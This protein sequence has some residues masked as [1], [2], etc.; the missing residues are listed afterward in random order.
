MTDTQA[1]PRFQSDSPRFLDALNYAATLHA[2][3]VR[4]ATSIPYVAHVLSVAGIAIEHGADE[5]EAI[6]ALLH[7]APEDCGGLHVL[8]E[9]RARFG[10][11]VT[12]IVAACSDTFET[13]KPPWVERKVR[14]IAHV[15]TASPSAR[16]VSMSDKLHNARAI[17]ADYRQL[18][19]AVFSR[20]KRGE[21]HSVLW[22][23]RRL[24]DE[25]NAANASSPL[26]QELA[27]VVAELETLTLAD[28]ASR[29]E[30]RRVYDEL[31]EALAAAAHV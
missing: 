1:S 16:L 8:E 24:A 17:L 29:A 9:I 7:D 27:R 25:F 28:D 2:G 18:G 15:R 22:Y 3:Q 26:A 14:Y 11:R 6:A 12:G 5:D 20:F 19:E 4:K 10:E 23:Y 30:R 13:P 31:N 21:S